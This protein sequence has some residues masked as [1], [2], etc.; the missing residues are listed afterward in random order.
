MEAVAEEVVVVVVVEVAGM[1]IG[2]AL[3]QGFVLSLEY[4]LSLFLFRF[5][6]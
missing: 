1:V 6:Y 4:L 2:V 5:V 3:T